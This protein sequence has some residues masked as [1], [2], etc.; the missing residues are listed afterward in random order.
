MTPAL[1]TST[2][3]RPNS[4]TPAHHRVD[5]GEVAD[6]GGEGQALAPSRPRRRARLLGGGL[7]DVDGGDVGAGR[8]QGQRGGVADPV[9]RAGDDGDAVG[10]SAHAGFPPAA[11]QRASFSCK[12]GRRWAASTMKR[13]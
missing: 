13:S 1:L 12:R 7:V 3:I 8:G 11:F 4:A 2:S 10:E 5:A 6:V 9:A